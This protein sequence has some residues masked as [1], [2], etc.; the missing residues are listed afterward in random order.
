MRRSVSAAGVV[1]ALSLLLLL[2]MVIIAVIAHVIFPEDPMAMVARPTQ[3]P[4]Q[5]ARY[6][7]GTDQLGRDIAAQLAYGGR[8]SLLIGFGA[9]AL[10][11][12]LGTGIG[13]TAG[14]WGGRT[15]AALMRITE[16]FQTIPSFLFAMVLVVIL[17]PSI[18][19]IMFAIGITA[20]PQVARLSRAEVM[21][22]RKVDYVAAATMMGLSHSRILL[23]HILPNSIMPVVVISAAVVAHAIL[24]EAALAFL[25]LGDPN[26]VSWG[27]M[28][29]NARQLLRTA[30]YMTALPGL[31]IFLTVICLTL[32]GNHLAD[33]L[34]P[35][36]GER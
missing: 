26:V 14:Y 19:S 9:A 8:V 34:N 5:S 7:L 20:W 17:Q 36:L 4:F 18:T 33:R 25:G 10:A 13:A 23:R 1:S 11:L 15:D 16:Y 2:G 35:R 3:W 32:L 21:R 29:G 6:Y 27:S 31:A 28:I 12:L 24:V 30:W 22:V